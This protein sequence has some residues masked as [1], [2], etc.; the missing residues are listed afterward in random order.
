[1]SEQAGNQSPVQMDLIA[2][3]NRHSSGAYA[4]RPEV[5]VKGQG[6]SLWDAE[7]HR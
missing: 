1:M 7:G 2:I 5:M 6:A 4:K 3:E